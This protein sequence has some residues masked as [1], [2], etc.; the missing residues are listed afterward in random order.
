M[1]LSE[2]ANTELSKYLQKSL[3]YEKRKIKKMAKMC[4]SGKNYLKQPNI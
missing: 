2:Y 1:L 4:N 3:F